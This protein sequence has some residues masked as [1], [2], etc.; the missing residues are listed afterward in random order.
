MDDILGF[1]IVDDLGDLILF[2]ERRAPGSSNAQHVLFSNFVMASTKFFS[3]LGGGDKS[4][5]V[6]DKSAIYIKYSSDQKYYFI[7]KA[8]VE[9][10]SSIMN[11]KLKELEEYIYKRKL[12]NLSD[13]EDNLLDKLREEILE[14]IKP[15]SNLH[16]FLE[17]I[18]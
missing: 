9:A 10:K 4:K 18:G 16:K 14:L 3:E 7:L 1:Y 15:K 11:K 5:I 8:S 2:H 17:V 6:L 13:M 12:R